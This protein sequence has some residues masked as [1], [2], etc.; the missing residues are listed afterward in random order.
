[1]AVGSAT[2]SVGVAAG[3]PHAAS[4][5]LIAT[6]IN[7]NERTVL[8]ISFLLDFLYDYEMINIRA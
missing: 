1:V 3:A 4:K 2:A 7:K 6:T 5:R 8:D